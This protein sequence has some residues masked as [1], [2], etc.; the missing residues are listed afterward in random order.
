MAKPK[1][2]TIIIVF[3]YVTWIAYLAAMVYVYGITGE[4]FPSEATLATAALFIVETVSLARLKM[5][6]EGQR[7]GEKK[8]NPL[9]E[10]IGL[11]NV[12][13]FEEEVQDIQDVSRAKHADKEMIE[14]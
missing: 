6:K 7:V 12:P 4:W 9:L 10:Q 5:A 8:Q 1:G 3:M 11:Y 14:L 2:S 13:D